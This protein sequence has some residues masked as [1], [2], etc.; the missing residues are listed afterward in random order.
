MVSASV[1]GNLIVLVYLDKSE[2]SSL[3]VVYCFLTLQ[4]KSITHVLVLSVGFNYSQDCTS[5]L[6]VHGTFRLH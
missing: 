5:K 6:S 1:G 4:Q 2:L 3:F